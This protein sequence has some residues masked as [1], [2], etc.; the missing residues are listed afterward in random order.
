MKLYHSKRKIYEHETLSSHFFG[1][2]YNTH[3]IIFRLDLNCI[4]DQLL[5]IYYN[6][7]I[8]NNY[9]L[10]AEG[11]RG[12]GEISVDYDKKAAGSSVILIS[13]RRYS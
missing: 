7:H 10:S 11:R 5:V 13:F 8:D 1:E 2:Q 9:F 6:F 12:G 4:I 3:T